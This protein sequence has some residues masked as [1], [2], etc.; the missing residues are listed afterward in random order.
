MSLT[1]CEFLQKKKQSLTHSLKDWPVLFA[2]DKT[3]MP[4][5][6][7]FRSGLNNCQQTYASLQKHNLA[8]VNRL[9][10][11]SYCDQKNPCYTVKLEL[12]PIKASFLVPVEVFCIP[13]AFP[14]ATLAKVPKC[15]QCSPSDT[16]EHTLKNYC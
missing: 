3:V 14:L 9:K 12:F 1:S 4:F 8:N 16:V 13:L 11:K 10:E 6:V 15:I 2:V 7:V 5:A